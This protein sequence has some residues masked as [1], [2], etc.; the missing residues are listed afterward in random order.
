VQV[1]YR[2]ALDRDKAKLENIFI[3]RTQKLSMEK[4]VVFCQAWINVVWKKMLSI[5]YSFLSIFLI[6]PKCSLEWILPPSFLV[7]KLA[8]DKN[9]YSLIFH[10]PNN[11]KDQW[12]RAY[13][14]LLQWVGQN[15]SQII[16]LI[17]NYGNWLGNKIQALCIKFDPVCP[18]GYL[19]WC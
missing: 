13:R 19:E 11:D 16:F 4:S 2:C 18:R 8:L 7:T 10:L 1:H 12:L 14:H 6:F 9:R 17:F 5:I 15:L 3:M